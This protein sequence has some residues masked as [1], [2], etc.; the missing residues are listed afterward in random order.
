MRRDVVFPNFK[1]KIPL[2]GATVHYIDYG[3][4]SLSNDL[5]QLPANLKSLKRL[6]VACRLESKDGIYSA[7]LAQ[8]FADLPRDASYDMMYVC[9]ESSP[10]I[11]QLLVDGVLFA[12]N[13]E[14][15]EPT[16]HVKV[17]AYISVKIAPNHFYI[18][19]NNDM[20]EAM[21]SASEFPLME[22]N[23]KCAGQLC[24]ALWEDAYY[25]ATILGVDEQGMFRFMNLFYPIHWPF[26]ANISGIKVHFIDY[27]NESYATDLRKL[28]ENLEKIERASMLCTLEN[29]NDGFSIG[30]VDKFT[31]LDADTEYEFE[32]VNRS[33]PCVVRLY[34]NGELFAD[35]ELYCNLPKNGHIEG[36]SDSIANGIVTEVANNN[37]L[38]GT[39]ATDNSST[40]IIDVASEAERINEVHFKS[41]EK[42][43]MGSFP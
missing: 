32:I 4:Q 39:N 36:N 12:E 33:S 20:E 28:P 24:A 18:Q 31:S 30:F 43:G 34:A 42:I 21:A 35:G 40:S 27:G 14:I 9:K 8:R 7:Q 17:K 19:L 22:D 2:T 5:R 15:T 25:R 13:K 23:F 37:G 11:V 6:A 38:N 29:A 41:V 3:N 10:A 16:E 26:N 1:I